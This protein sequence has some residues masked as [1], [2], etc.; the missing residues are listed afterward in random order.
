M[1]DAAAAVDRAEF[2]TGNGPS[3]GMPH[4]DQMTDDGRT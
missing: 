1:A 3:V 2:D 4:P